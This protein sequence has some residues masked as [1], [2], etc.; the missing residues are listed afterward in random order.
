MNSR[1]LIPVSVTKI[2]CLL[3]I[4]SGVVL[5]TDAPGALGGEFF[6][7]GDTNTDASR[8]IDGW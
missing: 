2:L 1:N 8:Y 6:R 4:S 7:R 3:A 5:I